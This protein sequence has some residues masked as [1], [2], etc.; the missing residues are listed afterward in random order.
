MTTVPAQFVTFPWSRRH[1]RSV[2]VDEND[3][4]EGFRNK[5]CQYSKLNGSPYSAILNFDQMLDYS[6]QAK[7][8]ENA[9]ASVYVLKEQVNFT[10]CNDHMFIQIPN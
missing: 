3:F 4:V 10:H 7:R 8:R 1:H 6:L 2:D 9:N 5:T